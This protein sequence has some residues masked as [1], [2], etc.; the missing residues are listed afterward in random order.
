MGGSFLAARLRSFGY[1]LAGLAFMLRT[2]GN[3]QIHLAV[4]VIVAALGLW[5]N[6]S[7]YDWLW[8]IAAMALVW[9]AEG[10]NTALENLCDVVSP[11][12]HDGIRRA[13]DVAA[14]AVL[15]AAIAAAA[16]GLTVFLPYLGNTGL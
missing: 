10:L 15:V 11:N 7:R 12:R 8:L 16:I 3:A 1:A 13:K 2:Q 5:L 6:I 9:I 14:G 4:T